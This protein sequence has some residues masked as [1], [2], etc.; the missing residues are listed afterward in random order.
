MDG[1]MCLQDRPPLWHLGAWG[2]LR[3]MRLCLRASAVL[4]AGNFRAQRENFPCC[5]EAA[6]SKMLLRVW[7]EIFARSAKILAA[8][9]RP[10]VIAADCICLPIAS[11]YRLH[12]ISCACKTCRPMHQFATLR[13]FV[14]VVV[15]FPL[16]YTVIFARSAKITAAAKRPTVEW[17]R[18]I[19]GP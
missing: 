11:D 18:K 1:A 6:P 8:A 16:I 2:A 12:L 10:R 14:P 7:F 15:H 17:K 19:F 4:W 9:K 5:R 13:V 3:G